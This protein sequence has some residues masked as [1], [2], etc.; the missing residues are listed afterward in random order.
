MRSPH[1]HGGN[2]PRSRPAEYRTTSARTADSGS[3]PCRARRPAA[4]SECWT[5]RWAR[6][7]WG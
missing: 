5:A 4:R 3:P 7:S 2:G 1:T 6:S